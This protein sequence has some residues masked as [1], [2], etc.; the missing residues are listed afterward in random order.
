MPPNL[1]LAMNTGR[2]PSGM[3]PAAE[4]TEQILSHKTLPLPRG[5]KPPPAVVDPAA[6]TVAPAPDAPGAKV[7]AGRGVVDG[8]GAQRVKRYDKMFG[9]GAPPKKKTRAVGTGNSKDQQP[10]SAPVTTAKGTEQ[11]EPSVST[12]QDMDWNAA[13]GEDESN[14]QG[15]AFANKDTVVCAG[16]IVRVVCT[17]KVDRQSEFLNGKLHLDQH[18]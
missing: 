2:D 10:A 12:K 15:N 6:A 3:F 11:A 16:S 8:K 17:F 13:I 4:L 5:R 1:L 9:A 18:R 7:A 14:L